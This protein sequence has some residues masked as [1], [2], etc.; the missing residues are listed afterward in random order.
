MTD[1]RL[2]EG[3]DGSFIVLEGRV[4]KAAGSDFMLDSPERRIGRNPFRR[5]LVHDQGDGL[6]VNFANDYQGGVKLNAVREISPHQIRT[7]GP[8]DTLDPTPI[9]VVHGG[10][11][12]EVHSESPIFV[13]DDGGGPKVTTLSLIGELRNLQS[14]ISA[15]QTKVAALEAKQ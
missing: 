2:D 15:L 12:F 1:V 10:I 7:G 4:V 5:A 9:L 3:S 8:F 14:Q 11:E 6:T 13:G